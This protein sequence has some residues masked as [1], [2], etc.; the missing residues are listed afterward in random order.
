VYWSEADYCEER[1][2]H[3]ASPSEA[4]A[5]F[6][7]NAGA[8]YPDRAWLLHDWDVWVANPYYVGPPVPH[9][10]SDEAYDYDAEDAENLEAE[11]AD[12]LARRGVNPDDDFIPF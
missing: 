12:K 1:D 10:E 7:R 4:V 8:E 2:S 3:V 5:E 11:M 6:G 9:P